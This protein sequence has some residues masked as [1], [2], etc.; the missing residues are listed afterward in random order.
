MNVRAVTARLL[1]AACMAW[2]LAACGSGT[3]PPAVAAVDGGSAPVAVDV[4]VVTPPAVDG[5]GV[6]DDAAATDGGAV[7]GGAVDGGVTPPAGPPTYWRDVAP[8]VNARCVQCHTAGGLAPFTLGTYDDVRP[9]AA[10]IVGITAS[11]TM[12]PW[13]PAADC[14][15][16]QNSRS[17]TDAEI[18]MLR[19]WSTAGTPEGDRATYVARTDAPSPLPDHSDITIE[20]AQAYVPQADLLDDYHCF[21]ID[22][23]LTA[24]RDVVG[25]RITPGE[26]RTVHHVIIY[27]IKAAEVPTV[28]ALDAATGGHGYTCFGGPGVAYGNNPAHLNVQF[29]TGWAPGS[30]PVSFPGGTGIR[31]S[32]GSRLVMQVHYNQVNGR[33]LSDRTRVELFYNPTP[34]LRQAYMIPVVQQDFTLNPGDPHA[35]ASVDFNLRSLG[36]PI[37]VTV[38]GSFPHMHVLGQDIRVDVQHPDGTSDCLIHVPAWNFHWQ[39]FYFYDEPYRVTPDDIVHLS[40][41]YDNSA[42]NQP[43]VDGVQQAPRTVHWGESTSDEMC[44]NFVYGTLL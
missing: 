33:G 39:Q 10:Q 16:I 30:P 41:H 6:A 18:A 3:V 14:R 17:L 15:S 37:S 25:V 4:G 29:V 35:V 21:V 7:D 44:L 13:P 11:R 42:A 22:P 26:R 12:P 32:T 1:I 27:E 28:V 2:G 19:A 36:L 38:Y 24:D 40:C 5:G 23:N 31:L 34:V 20:P 9:R 8:L 43:V